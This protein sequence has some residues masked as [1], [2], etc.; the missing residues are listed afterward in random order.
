M[1]KSTMI[2]LGVAVVSTLFN[3]FLVGKT[4]KFKDA[5]WSLISAAK[6]GK[7]S[8]EEFQEITDNIRKDLYS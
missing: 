3:I 2:I 5:L 7:I 6:D 8:E 4:F 1:E